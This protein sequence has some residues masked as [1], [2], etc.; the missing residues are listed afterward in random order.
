MVNTV[1]VTQTP[2]T[3]LN[4]PNSKMNQG[5]SE[6]YLQEKILKMDSQKID[7]FLKDAE[8]HWKQILQYVHPKFLLLLHIDWAQSWIEHNS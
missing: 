2:P 4:I 6:K 1:N 3:V 7:M 8:E 5:W